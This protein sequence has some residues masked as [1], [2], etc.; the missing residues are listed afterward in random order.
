MRKYFL[1][2]R[3]A[4]RVNFGLSVLSPRQL[5]A[6]KRDLWMVPLIGLGLVGL[7]PLL[8]YYLKGIKWI[9]GLL[10][11]MGQ[12][13]AI[14]TFALLMG[15]FLVMV[16]GFYYVISS[17]YFSKDLNILVPLPL[18]PAQ[19]LL[20][21]FSVIVVN[22]YL[23]AGPLVLPVLIYY[24]ILSHG[25]PWYWIQAAAVYFLLPVIPLAFVA[26]VVVVLLRFVNIGRKKDA[27]IVVGSLVLMTAAL[28]LQFFINRSAGDNVGPETFIRLFTSPDGLIQSIGSKF[29][30]SIWATKA[31]GYGS[32]APGPAHFALF[33]AVS[34]GLFVALFLVSRKLFY[35]GL[36]GLSE[37]TGK[38]RI[39]SRDR[40][41]ARISSG[42]RPVRAIFGRE[43]RIMNRTP[44]FLLNGVLSVV[45]I[46]VIFIIMAKAGGGKGSDATE[47]LVLLG[48][49]HPTT[50]ALGAALF[51]TICGCLNGTAPST[52]SRE[53]GQFW[54][55]KVIPA[56]PAEQATGK[57]LHSYAI[58]GLG[59]V[60][61][62]VASITVFRM[63]ASSLALAVPLALM[64]AAV[65]TALG[66]IID[67]ARPLLNW[68]NPQKAIKQNF[69]V[70][71]AFFADAGI[72]AALTFGAVKMAKRG[73]KTGAIV[74]VLAVVLAVAALT[75]F[76]LLMGF[77]AKRYRDIEV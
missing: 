34:V 4:L 14:L 20:S 3:I 60:V 44:I 51:M 22:E 35:R 36:I 40:L 65:L 8:F 69:N 64:A 42:R 33:A 10:Q 55:S 39:L 18:S 74:A 32:A 21:K 59:L 27:L 23:T 24:G 17:F 7:V 53:G 2:L 31:L 15:Q 19:V 13:A 48:S 56:S 16:F 29:P 73:M 63:K 52:F 11:P 49:A 45:L 72:L 37:T 50:A 76:R 41:S 57:F 66:M 26:L 9:F 54:M 68:T 71:L 12:Q 67:L 30:P 5:W 62:A 46:P 70:L 75:G 28:S 1:C 61:A 6:K 43:L 47:I 38:R 58:A 77:A 25:G